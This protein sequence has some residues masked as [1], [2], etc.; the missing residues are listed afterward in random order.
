MCA[1]ENL[2]N[3]EALD[4]GGLSRQKQTKP[5]ER[6]AVHMAPFLF[7]VRGSAGI[8]SGEHSSSMN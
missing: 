7:S 8:N 1:L 2:V 6:Y 5:T 4:Q 3:E